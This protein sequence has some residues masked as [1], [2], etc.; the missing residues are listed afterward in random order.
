MAIISNVFA[1]V[2]VPAR[3]AP[4][5]FY[6]RYRTVDETGLSHSDLWALMKSHAFPTAAEF[7]TTYTVER[8]FERAPE[9]WAAGDVKCWMAE[10]ACHRANG[11]MNGTAVLESSPPPPIQHKE[12]VRLVKRKPRTERAHL[13]KR[14]PRRERLHLFGRKPR[15][16]WRVVS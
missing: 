11:K 1:L 4:P 9:S 16:I 3:R 7:T 2:D 10:R 12:R 15:N 6:D 14:K 5:M 13:V 8:G